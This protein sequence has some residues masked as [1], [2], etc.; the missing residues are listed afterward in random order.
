MSKWVVDIHGDIDG[1]YEI[2]G[3]YKES[4]LNKIRKEIYDEIVSHSG[5]GEEVTQAYADG[6]TRGLKIINKYS[7]K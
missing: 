2:I 6:L 5:T 7:N 4:D 3:E 1:D